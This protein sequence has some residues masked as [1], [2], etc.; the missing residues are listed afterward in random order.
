M[1]T[2][3][4]R[5]T[6]DGRNTRTHSSSSSSSARTRHQMRN[7]KLKGILQRMPQEKGY[8]LIENVGVN[9][10]KRRQGKREQEMTR[11]RERERRRKKPTGVD[12]R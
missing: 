2:V 10:G 5:E 8:R 4:E 12:L 6:V 3:S 1:G 9:D 11:E 7:V